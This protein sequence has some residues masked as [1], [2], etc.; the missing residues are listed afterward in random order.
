VSKLNG[1][2]VA[3]IPAR[4]GS[5][6]IPRKNIKPFNG[7]P[8]IEWPIRSCISSPEVGEIIVSTEDDEIAAVALEAGASKVIKRPPELATSSAGTS[9]V[10]QHSITELG[11]AEETPVFCIY[12]TAPIVPV[13]LEEAMEIFRV[14]PS[15]FVVTVGRHRSPL[16]RS[17]RSVGNG[18]MTL[19]S[20]ENSLSRTQ[21]LPQSYF[22]AGKLYLATA[23]LWQKQ[24][25]M[26][27]GKFIA[28]H[29]P[30]WAAVD[31]DEPEDWEVAEGLHRLFI[32]EKP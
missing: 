8:M 28:Y 11:L 3:I 25:T 32:L 23:S 20:P 19:I 21:D 27:E 9:P 6:R 5:S 13:N 31:L 15:D 26:M 2:A 12:P 17:L 14:N 30:D 29:L 24:R 4:G 22:D 18:Y 7:R 1:R 16:E 10:I